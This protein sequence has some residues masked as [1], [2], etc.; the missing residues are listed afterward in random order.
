VDVA[1]E[2]RFRAQIRKD[3]TTRAEIKHGI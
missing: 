2:Y 1:L 3:L